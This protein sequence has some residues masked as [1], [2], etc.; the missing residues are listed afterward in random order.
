MI[1][2]PRIPRPTAKRLNLYL[3]ECEELLAVGHSKASSQMLADA[4]G[5]TAAQIRKDLTHLSVLGQPGVGYSLLELSQTLRETIGLTRSW[6][7]V[8]V[9]VGNIGRAVLSYAPFR[10]EN[11]AIVA[12]FDTNTEIVGKSWS[13]RVVHPMH[14]LKSVV[15]QLRA[16]LGIVAVP[17]DAAQ[18][19]VDQLVAAGVRG[20]LN[21]APR[22]V[23]VPE[24]MQITSVDFQVELRRLVFEVVLAGEDKVEGVV[25][26]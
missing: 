20:I 9:G 22:R 19:V 5:L 16:E 25:R 18:D 4:L 15:K 13:G 11:F 1:S 10:S 24:G 3:R 12:A 2:R 26:G 17:A 14:E 6:R 23:I 8:I 21:F 7:A